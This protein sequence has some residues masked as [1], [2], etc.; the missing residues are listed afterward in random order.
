MPAPRVRQNRRLFVAR[1]SGERL[2]PRWAPAIATLSLDTTFQTIEGYGTHLNLDSSLTDPTLLSAYVDAG[3]NMVRLEVGPSLYTLQNSGDLTIPIPIEADLDANIA[4]FDFERGGWAELDDA[5]RWMRDN[6]MEPE[7]FRLT[8]SVWSPP[9]WLKI[10]TGTQINWTNWD[11]TARSDYGPFLPYGPT[12]GNSGGGRVDPA[13]YQEMARW[14]LSFVKGYSEFVGIPIDSFSFQNEPDYEGFYNTT[15]YGRRAV[16]PADPTKGYVTDWTIYADAFQA[17]VDELALHPDITTRMIGPEIMTVSPWANGNSDKVRTALADRGLL[18]HMDII[19]AHGYEGVSDSAVGWDTFWRRYGSDGKPIYMTEHSGEIQS[20]LDGVDAAGKPANGALSLALKIHNA[21]VYGHSSSF[22]YWSFSNSTEKSSLVQPANRSTPEMDPKYAAMV[23]FSRFIRPGAVRIG[24]NFENGW[25]AIGGSGRLDAHRSLNV[26][27]YYHPEDRQLTTVLVNMRNTADT[28]TVVLPDTLDVRSLRVYRSTGT[29]RVAEQP[30]ISVIDGRAVVQVPPNSVVTLTGIN[31]SGDDWQTG[32]PPGWEA[33]DVGGPALAGSTTVSD[34]TWTLRAAGAD[35]WNT[36]DEFQFAAREAWRDATVTAR[37]DSVPNTNAWAKAGVMIRGSAAADAPFAA[38]FQL[39][40]NE[41]VFQ[42]RS[43][44]GANATFNWERP[45]AGTGAKFVRIERIG[46]SFSG[47]YSLDGVSWT[48]LGDPV[49]IA[50]PETAHVGL[51]Y[52]SHATGT[53]GTATFSEVTVSTANEAPTIESVTAT[54]SADA[55]SVELAVVANDDYP[56]SDLGYS[57]RLVDGPAPVL[58]SPA[59]PSARIATAAVTA[60]GDYV[61][62]VTA[63]DRGTESVSGRVTINVASRPAELVV[64]PANPITPTRGSVSLEGAVLDQFGLPVAGTLTWTIVSGSGTINAA[65]QFTAGAAAGHTVVRANAGNRFGEVTIAVLDPETPLAT[66]QFE[67]G[68]TGGGTQILSFHAGYRG[69]GF[70]DFPGNGGFAEFTAVDGGIGGENL[71]WIRYALG[72]TTARAGRLTVNGNSQSV[73]FAPTGS[74]T[75]WQL[76]AVPVNL[77]A[78]S[79][80]AIRIESI[81]QDL[82]N[83]DELRVGR[84]TTP[85]PVVETM[86]TPAGQMTIDGRSRSGPLAV[87]KTGGGS[88]VL[89]AAADFSG[90]VRVTDGQVIVQDVAA[91]GTGGLA[92]SDGSVSLEVGYGTVSLTAL[93][94]GSTGRIDIGTGGLRIA[95]GGFDET[96]VRHWLLAGRNGGGWDGATGI[97]SRAATAGSGRTIGYRIKDGDMFVSWAAAGDADL[98]GVVSVFDLTQVVSGGQYNVG[99]A[100]PAT[101]RW[102]DGDFNY[103]GRV[104]L[105]D[106]VAINSTGLFNRGNYRL[107]TGTGP[108]SSP[109]LTAAFAMLAEESSPAKPARRS[110]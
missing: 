37:V 39:P 106:L 27:S 81:G 43:E 64:S 42:W 44:A 16:D 9:H 82:A 54:V 48:Q 98:D 79:N 20:W 40:G 21:F 12:G 10:P 29:D 2:E 103:D 86:H 77:R 102:S 85:G 53:L 52:T 83:L 35:I 70:V 67:E 22:E 66:L 7:R 109:A 55:T 110:L 49:S 14:V 18:Q 107:G 57:W 94:L 31:E 76:L 95:A 5:I 28:T 80:N 11:G 68:T 100:S 36:A 45:G 62:E 60:G 73:S 19:G 90:G 30:A 59:E 56:A 58:F 91:L 25:T 96:Q 46:D 74:W 63:T 41:V 108:G 3:F 23:Q 104:N 92:V 47:A 38:V 72:A 15:S 69:A 34:G 75:T 88:L 78:G 61:F 84:L 51:A 71:I 1:L 6:S 105:L 24:A 8:G 97:V 87:E 13:H 101:A 99:G 17:V 4:R 50:L 65:G 26:G 33:A 32:L 89:A 93:D